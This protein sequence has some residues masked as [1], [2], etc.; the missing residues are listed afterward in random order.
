MCITF[1]SKY[2]SQKTNAWIVVKIPQNDELVFPVLKTKKINEQM[3][4]PD[5]YRRDP[6]DIA[7]QFLAIPLV[8][9]QNY[10]RTDPILVMELH[11]LHFGMCDLLGSNIIITKTCKLV[12]KILRRF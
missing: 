1:Y 3:H 5:M 6:Y 9:Q 7:S 12:K 11:V 4:S 10:N 8:I 2:N